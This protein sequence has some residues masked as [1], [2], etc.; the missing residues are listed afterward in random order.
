MSA[1]P[2]KSIY[3]SETK[4]AMRNCTLKYYAAM[5]GT[6]EQTLRDTVLADLGLDREGKTSYDLGSKTVQVSAW[7]RT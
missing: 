2:R 6:D 3:Y 5:R 1:A 4:T 7:R